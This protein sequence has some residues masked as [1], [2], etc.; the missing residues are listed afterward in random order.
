MVAC[1]VSDM[2][3]VALLAIIVTARHDIARLLFFIYTFLTFGAYVV[4]FV[5]NSLVF[6]IVASHI[7]VVQSLHDRNRLLETRQVAIAT[8]A[9]AVVPLVC[10][11]PAFLTLSSALA[12]I[13]PM[14]ELDEKVIFITQLWLAASPLFDALITM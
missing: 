7:R 6:R 1:F 14:Y 9:Q 4:T 5:S 3:P 10:Q 8:L 12:L 13:Q 11:V 2:M